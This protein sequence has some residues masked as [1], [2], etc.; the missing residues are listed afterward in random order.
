MYIYIF[1]CIYFLFIYIYIHMNMY[2]HNVYICDIYIYKHKHQLLCCAYGG[3]T[4][5][6]ICVCVAARHVRASTRDCNIKH[7]STYTNQ[8]V[9]FGEGRVK[10]ESEVVPHQCPEVGPYQ[11]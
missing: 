10:I 8:S 2:A 6:R 9:N 3:C 7:L 1:I 11:C 4:S 5:V